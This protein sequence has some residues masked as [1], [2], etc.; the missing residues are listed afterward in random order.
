MRNYYVLLCL[1]AVCQRMGLD[2]GDRLEINARKVK[3]LVRTL[4]DKSKFPPFE[5]FDVIHDYMQTNS[6]KTQARLRKRGQKGVF[7]IFFLRL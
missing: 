1:Q 5:D 3:F 2:T 4:P 7:F 6:R